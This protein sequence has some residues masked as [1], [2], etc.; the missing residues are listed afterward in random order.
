[1]RVRFAGTTLVGLALLAISM[2]WAGGSA[3]VHVQPSSEHDVQPPDVLFPVDGA[4]RMSDDPV[5]PLDLEL[6]FELGQ[7]DGDL[8]FGE[9]VDL[10][11][12]RDSLLAVADRF[13]CAVRVF[14]FPSGEPVSE[15]GGCGDGPGEFRRVVSIAF[16]A[17]TLLVYDFGRS[18]LFRMDPVQGEEL[19]SEMSPLPYTEAP[20][21]HLDARDD[22]I[23][24]QPSWYRTTRR[25]LL[26][27]RYDSGETWEG[28]VD[29]EISLTNRDVSMTRSAPACLFRTDG[30]A[31]A[32]NPWALQ[33]VVLDDRLDP[34]FDHVDQTSWV[35]PREE[36]EGHWTPGFV[37]PSVACGDSL[38]MVRYRDSERLPDHRWRVQR[39]LVLIVSSSGEIVQREAVADT[40]WPHPSAMVPAAATDDVFFL[41]QNAWGPHPMVRGYRVQGWQ[42]GS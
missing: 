36:R 24:Y 39:G 18:R 1:M 7:L 5:D 23:L 12:S 4:E 22:L 27:S 37:V 28:L 13:G 17:D 25:T 21:S 41:Y 31:L 10:A 6:I 40:A 38:A 26:L 34:L 30:R 42:R 14:R 9:I 15:L 16:K 3:A 32:A 35:G 33:A 19:G 11:V 29:S 8:A 2:S 20:Y